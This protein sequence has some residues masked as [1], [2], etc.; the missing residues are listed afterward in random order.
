M[1]G[2]ELMRTD[3]LAG[4]GVDIGLDAEAKIGIANRKMYQ[5]STSKHWDARA[6][7]AK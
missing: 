7:R 5:E 4:Q 3:L 1:G 6:C 2:L